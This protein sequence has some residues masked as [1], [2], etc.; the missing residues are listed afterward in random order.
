MQRFEVRTYN[1]FPCESFAACR[2]NTVHTFSI[3]GFVGNKAK[4][5][6]S[7]RL[8]QESKAR[9]NFRKANI[10]YPLIRT[11]V[12]TPV[13]RFALLPYYRRAVSVFLKI[14]Q[15]LQGKTCNRVLFSVKLQTALLGY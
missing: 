11:P 10:S 7:K 1:V 12:E 3:E 4:G 13:L 6:I 15:N 9:Q 14:L 2:C 5:Q 8:F